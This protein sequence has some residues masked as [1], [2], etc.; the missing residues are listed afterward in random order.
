MATR[1]RGDEGGSDH[2]MSSAR[3]RSIM[4]VISLG[5][6]VLA[7]LGC[8]AGVRGNSDSRVST[9]SQ[10]QVANDARQYRQHATELREMA[11]RRQMEADVLA[12]KDNPDLERIEGKRELAKDLLEAADQFEAKA[13][14]LQ[15]EVP[16][17]MV[18]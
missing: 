10:Q 1:Q 9:P 7:T 13:R 17:G 14:E 4:Q 2:E 6:V 15:R 5:A 3:R 11:R 16:H 8:S 12:Q 18:Q